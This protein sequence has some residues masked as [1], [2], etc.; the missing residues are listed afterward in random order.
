MAVLITDK[1]SGW[2][3]DTRFEAA[4]INFLQT[5]IYPARELRRVASF[6][7]KAAR[8]A[9]AKPAAAPTGDRDAKS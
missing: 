4:A 9:G 3:A 7:K 8:F 5:E 6:V 1:T 2:R